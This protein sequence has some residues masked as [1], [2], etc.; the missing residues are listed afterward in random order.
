MTL[1][2]HPISNPFPPCPPTLTMTSNMN[3]SLNAPRQPQNPSMNITTPKQM[4][5]ILGL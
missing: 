2:H 1:I 3:T 5:I 4:R